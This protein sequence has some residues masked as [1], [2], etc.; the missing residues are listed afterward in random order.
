M[1]GIITFH[2][3]INYGAVLQAYA[4]SKYINDIG[5]NVEIIDYKSN[6]IS[7]FYNPLYPINKKFNIISICDEQT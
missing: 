4:L 3:A 1:I 7:K 6:F 5:G 2:R